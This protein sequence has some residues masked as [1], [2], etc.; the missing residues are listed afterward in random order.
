MVSLLLAVI[1]MSFIS[2]GLP[3]GLLGAGWP[4]IYSQMQVP[5]SYAGIL[6]LIIAG[7]TVLT[8]LQSDRLTKKYNTALVTI[9]S[10]ATTAIAL[11]GFSIST[12]F[13]MLCLF[14]IPYGL[15]AGSVDA[16]LNNYVS[17]HFKSRHMSWLHCM[18]GLG[19]TTGPLFMSY[20]LTSGAGWNK[21]Y[22]YVFYLQVVL[23]FIL[24]LSYPLWI[25]GIKITSGKDKTIKEAPLK[26]KEILK[27][28]GTIEVMIVFFVYCAIEQTTGLWAS[29]Y[30]VLNRGISA[31]SAASFAG[32]FFLGITIGRAI[33]GF[34]TFKLNDNQM[35]KS[36]FFIIA[37]GIVII[38]LPFA[39]MLTFIGFITIGLGCAPIFPSVIHSTPTNFGADKSQAII[40][41][42]MAS[43]YLGSGIMP[44]FFGFIANNISISIMP[45]YLI[46]L[47]ILMVSAYKSLLRKREIN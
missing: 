29:S 15:G 3:D 23:T 45:I 31:E 1:Y 44:S 13:Y 27:I 37:L 10:V 4:T 5:L 24:V 16:A 41:V 22:R 18:W 6:Q 20:A 35:I 7:S 39:N 26:L 11:F 40:G 30:L 42:Q 47:L 28:P 33:S 17:L 14:S 19:A 32:L 25:K 21:G 2:L 8:S 38:L 43:A 12:K 46:I 9:F 36:G 34:V